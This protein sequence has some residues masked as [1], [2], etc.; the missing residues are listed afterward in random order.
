MI[1][2]LRGFVKSIPTLV[3]SLAL[4]VA[5]WISAIN[6]S[7]PVKQQPYPRA[8]QIE[9]KNLDPALVVSSDVPTQVTATFSAPTSIWDRMLTDRA[10]VH[11]WID[12]SGLGPGTHTV[13]VRVE[14][15]SQFQPTKLVTQSPQNV[16]ITL[17]RLVTSEFPVDLTL[18]GEPAV[19]FQAET[20][21]LSQDKVEVRGPSS[22]VQQVSKAVVTLDL[23]QVS[24]SINRSLDVQLVDANGD[25]V[26]GV[27]YTPRQIIVNQAVSQRGGYRNVV[28]KV[29]WTGQ[30]ANGY[31]LTNISV[32]PPTVTVF[33]SNPQLMNA[34]PGYVETN[35]IDLTGVKDDLERRLSLNL[36][37][38][39]EVVGDQTDL[40]D[41]KVL[42]QVGVATIEGNVTMPGLRVQVTGMD[43]ALSA[44][45][46]PE[47]VD[48]I[49]S[50]PVPLLDRI[51][52]S[53]VRVMVDVT[54]VGAGTYQLA[55]KVIL[56]ISELQV[57]SILPSSIEVVVGPKRNVTPTP[58]LTPLPPNGPTP[59]PTP[60]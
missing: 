33:S 8:M 52:E 29:S 20:P 53:D 27:T 14:P 17:E 34:L 54:G 19:G 39:V 25:P 15:L 9:R 32:F 47:T 37:N 42:V 51:T 1:A 60:R 18:R 46:S 23:A 59:T 11:A 26:D 16:T 7:D 49:I 22:R 5:V 44:N 21:K 36:P 10:P 50:G 28:V 3:L 6:A 2:I 35:P 56:S 57:E 24:D 58:T 38:G 31:R 41:Q 40:V 45:L 13:P 43:E 48:V 4:S 55:P 12:L 30:V